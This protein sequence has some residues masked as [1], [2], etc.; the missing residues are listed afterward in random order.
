MFI[1][2]REKA[3]KIKAESSTT[4]LL[5]SNASAASSLVSRS[6]C[7]AF[8][9]LSSFVIRWPSVSIS[10]MVAAFADWPNPENASHVRSFLG[11]SNYFRSFI[12]GYSSLL[13]PLIDQEGCG[14]GMG[15]CMPEFV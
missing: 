3:E 10:A 12:Q 5:A 14:L 13:R 15:C 8:S 7:S 1:D 11:L 2:N 4:S 6:A 9:S